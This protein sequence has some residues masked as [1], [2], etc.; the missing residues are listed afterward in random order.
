MIVFPEADVN[1][2]RLTQKDLLIQGKSDKETLGCTKQQQWKDKTVR[3]IYCEEL[4]VHQSRYVRY[5]DST[6]NS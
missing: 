5:E 4:A 6:I 3:R 2:Q 1:G